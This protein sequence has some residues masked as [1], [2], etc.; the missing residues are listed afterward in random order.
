MVRNFNELMILM[1][2]G[3]WKK[4]PAILYTYIS[5]LNNNIAIGFL[6]TKL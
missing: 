2:I 3:M 4:G 1:L 5:L 6:L